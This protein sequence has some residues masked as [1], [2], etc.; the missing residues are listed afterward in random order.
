VSDEDQLR[1]LFGSIRLLAEI[2]THE[3]PETGFVV[4]RGAVSEYG[5][6]EAEAEAWR[7]VREFV[8]L[9]TEPFSS[10]KELRSR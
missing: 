1:D 2:H 4:L 5:Q 8:G 3:Q 6:M 7:V 10:Y 9:Q